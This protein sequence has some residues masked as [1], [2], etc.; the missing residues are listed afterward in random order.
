MI[1]KRWIWAVVLGF[2]VLTAGEVGLFLRVNGPE[3]ARRRADDV[4]GQPQMAQ[5]GS[6]RAGDHVPSQASVTVEPAAPL[7][8]AGD[9]PDATERHTVGQPAASD[10]SRARLGV[11][12]RLVERGRF[13]EAAELYERHL[14]SWPD[15]RTARLRLAEVLVAI[16]AFDR[17][18]A[19]YRMAL[20]HAPDDDETRL[21]LARVL[22]SSKRYGESIEE[23][24]RVLGDR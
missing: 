15:D 2:A 18:A 16:Q 8:A 9:M 24:R 13:S 17:A 14:A 3:I 23:Y 5:S 6:P 10:E 11:A 12:S 22:S 20:S 4:R 1:A 7:R 19:A 21:K